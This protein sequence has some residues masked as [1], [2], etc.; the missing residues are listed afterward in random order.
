MPIRKDDEGKRWVEM[1]L[2]VPGTP[3]QVWQA[4]ATGPGTAAWFTRAQIDG[5]VGGKIELDFGDGTRTQGEVT[6]WQPPHH[7]AYVERDWAEGAP[8][9]ATEITITGR[10]GARCVLRMVHSLYTSEAEWEDQLESFE[11]GWP[12]FFEVLR[13]YLRHFAGQEA[14]AFMVSASVGSGASAAWQRLVAAFGVPGASVGERVGSPALPEGVSGVVEHVHQD[15]QQRFMVMRLEAP[16][17]GIILMGAYEREGK[18]RVSVCRY[19]YGDG[20]SERA[21]SL[22]PVWQNWANRTFGAPN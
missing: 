18:T 10:S 11:S 19:V 4:L 8:P 2:F 14:D 13:V 7:F 15:A 6:A 17:P 12:G 5:R 3:E 1:E 22:R 9:V 16:T 21:L 20:A